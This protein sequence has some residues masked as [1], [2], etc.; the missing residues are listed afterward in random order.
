MGHSSDL[1]LEKGIK[2]GPHAI[3]SQAACS[4]SFSLVYRALQTPLSLDMFTV[5]ANQKNQG[6]RKKMMTY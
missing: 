3:Y 5:T 2:L 6:S 1:N 4:T